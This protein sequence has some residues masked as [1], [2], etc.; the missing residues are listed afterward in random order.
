MSTP[1]EHD[2]RP[3]RADAARNREAILCA[4]GTA[5]AE[6]GSDISLEEIAR[7]AGVGVGTVYRRFP[8]HDAL[9]EAVLDEKMTAYAD[10][11]EAAAER[12]LVEPAEA[13]AAYIGFI[14]DQ[15][16]DDRAFAQLMCDRPHGS[17]LFAAQQ[18]RAF[19]AT[20]L[21][22]DRARAAG[23]VRSDLHHSDLILLIQATNGVISGGG[24]AAAEASRRL[25]HFLLQA[26]RVAGSESAPAVP[27]PWS[28]V[29]GSAP[30]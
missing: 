17:A 30:C 3:L 14:V 24:P 1:A 25:A 19:A 23:A 28:G 12:A 16:I 13:F 11:T 18:H 7:R 9:I 8:T 26:F 5:L 15:Q 10:R 27:A 21:L 4:A 20:V 6:E 2:E 22:V 29:D